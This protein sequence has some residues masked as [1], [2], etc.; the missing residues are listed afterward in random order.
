MSA[1]VRIAHSAVGQFG[2]G[3]VVAKSLLGDIDNLLGLGAVEEYDD[4]IPANA[5]HGEDTLT[6]FA[7]AQE[8]GIDVR[9]TEEELAQAAANKEDQADEDKPADE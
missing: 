7:P 9:P 4:P 6:H 5:I 3:Q 8:A 1:F 2:H